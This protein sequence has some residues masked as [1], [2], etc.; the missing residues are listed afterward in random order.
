MKPSL[1]VKKDAHIVD[2]AV[3]K[4]IRK[5]RNSRGI[6]QG[7]MANALGLSFQQIQKYESTATR[8]SASRMYEM[9]QILDV[10]PADFF[11]DVVGDPAVQVLG[12]AQQ[13]VEDVFGE[14][15]FAFKYEFS[16]VAEF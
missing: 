6:S 1:G 2:A 7:D 11:M 15:T 3:G 4:K 16:K 12:K 5:L 13:E 9:A 10:T 8:V 14:R